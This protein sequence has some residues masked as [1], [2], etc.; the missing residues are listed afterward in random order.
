MA[1]PVQAFA[2]LERRQDS[3]RTGPPLLALTLRSPDPL[4]PHTGEEINAL[5][6]SHGKKEADP[7]RKSRLL[8]VLFRRPSQEWG[9]LKPT[10]YKTSL[11]S[12]CGPLEKPK[13]DRQCLSHN[14]LRVVFAL[15][16]FCR[17]HLGHRL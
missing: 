13:E 14:I 10:V 11:G 4:Q 16:M 8:R 17:W 12:S 5:L 2:E 15:L 3:V 6:L 9:V 7:G 1:I